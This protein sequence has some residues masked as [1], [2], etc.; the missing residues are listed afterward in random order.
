MGN[1]D[2]QYQ[3]V[4]ETA[5]AWGVS[6]R[7]VNLCITQGRLPDAVKM[8]NMWLVPR[9]TPKPIDRRRHT[10]LERTSPYSF[11]SALTEI[12]AATTRPMPAKDPES[13]IETVDLENYRLQYIAEIA[14][15]R[16]DFERTK[17]SYLHTIGDEV[18]QL[19]ATSVAIAAAI[20]S[21]DY[22]FYLEIEEFLNGII[23]SSQ[24]LAVKTFAELCLSTAY[25][26]TFAPNMTP[27]WLQCGD[28][29]PLQENLR[30]AAVYMR[31]K[32]LIATSRYEAALAAS[33]TALA[34]STR[35]DC[36]LFHDIYLRITCA[37][38]CYDLGRIDEVDRWLTDAVM[39]A[40]PHGFITPFAES[41]TMFG[42]R[43]EQII[44]REYPQF[45]DAITAQWE[46][47]FT[48]WLSFHNLFTKDNITLMLSLR[49]YQIAQL[50]ARGTS[51]KRI[52]ELLHMSHG[53][54]KNILSRIYAELF[55]SS[56]EELA[57]FVL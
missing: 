43:L 50:A 3:T 7:Y 16:G 5:D 25:V 10:P 57:H 17:A 20:S 56:R 32:Y 27:E 13:V 6:R 18:A 14:Y 29:S 1:S 35:D 36:F 9:G 21:G 55:I 42:G 28:F 39:L 41:L 48:N 11:S 4:K 38:A 22:P 54:I 12:I 19:R 34:M 47:T 40:L 31:A 52:A 23:A 44:E 8:G 24:D 33:E 37:A 45:F 51:N 30:L 46:S 53:S 49:D 15:L 2:P 26:S